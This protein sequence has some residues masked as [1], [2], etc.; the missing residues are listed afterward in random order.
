MNTYFDG[1]VI[2]ITET[3]GEYTIYNKKTKEVIYTNRTK[4]WV[5]EYINYVLKMEKEIEEIEEE[6]MEMCMEEEV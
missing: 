3:F 1:K 6:M 5:D 4:E 2:K